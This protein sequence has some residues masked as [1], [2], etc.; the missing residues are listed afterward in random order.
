M[1]DLRKA[2]LDSQTAFKDEA[3]VFT[4]KQTMPNAR[5]SLLA[6]SR[7]LALDS[8]KDT[9]S[10]NNFTSWFTSSDGSIL[11]GDNGNG[12]INLRVSGGLGSNWNRIDQGTSDFGLIPKQAGDDV[13]V[14]A[15]GRHKAYDG[16]NY[17]NISA[18]AVLEEVTVGLAHC[19]HTTFANALAAITD[20]SYNKPYTIVG[21]A[22]SY[23]STISC[24]SWVNMDLSH[25]SQTQGMDAAKDM[26]A[27]VAFSRVY[28]G[29]GFYS[30]MATV[31][32]ISTFYVDRLE[33]YGTVGATSASGILNMVVGY[34][35]HDANSSNTGAGAYG[36][37]AGLGGGVLVANTNLLKNRT[38]S[39]Y[40]SYGIATRDGLQFHII[41]ALLGE[42]DGT[43]VGW[44]AR[45]DGH[46]AWVL[47]NFIG[48]DKCLDWN[49][50]ENALM[51][52]AIIPE[53]LTASTIAGS[54]TNYITANYNGSD[55][56][57]AAGATLYAMINKNNG[58]ITNNGTLEGIIGND[59]YGTKKFYDDDIEQ[60]GGSFTSSAI[61]TQYVPNGSGG[62]WVVDIGSGGSSSAEIN[63]SG[64]L[65]AMA[66]KGEAFS[67]A[68]SIFQIDVIN[69]GVRRFRSTSQTIT[70]GTYTSLDT[71]QYNIFYLNPSAG[72]IDIQ[73]FA[74]GAV[75][76][77]A[78]KLVRLDPANIITFNQMNSLGTQQIRTATN[79]IESYTAGRFGVADAVYQG[80]YWY[81][82]LLATKLS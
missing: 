51:T 70:S 7:L 74:N 57:I 5:L 65:I 73:G 68:N 32:D 52:N 4:Q 47:N 9:V 12:T 55:L 3:N 43:S 25:C 71:S 78:V 22:D 41:N 39:G 53:S 67:T 6:A 35:L 61:F 17:N 37:D 49:G 11:L 80:S 42:G 1:A 30:N 2:Q 76:Q 20:A 82:S 79:A 60:H 16:T 10:V 59:F 26:S 24:K 38:Q 8:N 13:L 31:D 50:G 36:Y 33:S 45:N 48:G 77:H 66:R 14:D 27:H 21:A 28:S 18:N 54:N 56:N 64:G 19:D 69:R 72:N 58:T 34:A 63:I 46:S 44:W 23:N 62:K 40:T 75:N 81:T 29:V 15:S